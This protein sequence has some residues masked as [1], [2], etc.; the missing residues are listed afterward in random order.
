MFNC[1]SNEE[2]QE[3]V[4]MNER[5][6]NKTIDFEHLVIIPEM[7][8]SKLHMRSKTKYAFWILALMQLPVPIILFIFKM[9]KSKNFINEF[10]EKE[11][12]KG[13]LNKN[14]DD[15]NDLVDM[16]ENRNLSFSEKFQQLPFIIWE[17]LCKY[18]DNSMPVFK[19]TAL[20]ASMVFLFDGL[21]VSN[22]V[23]DLNKTV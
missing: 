17:Y 23:I 4:R 6:Y 10:D 19:M 11:L 8:K 2:I 21:Q 20:M 16:D 14:K 15:Y 13:D 9:T 1:Y 7:L 22:I 18:F 5:L 12:Y 3:Y